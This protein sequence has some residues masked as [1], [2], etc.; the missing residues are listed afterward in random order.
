[1]TGKGIMYATGGSRG[2]G[3]EGFT[4]H[5]ACT[6]CAGAEPATCELALLPQTPDLEALHC[7]DKCSLQEL[8]RAAREQ[9]CRSALSEVL[10]RHF[11]RSKSG[12][13]RT[14]SV[15]QIHEPQLAVICRY[16]VTTRKRVYIHTYPRH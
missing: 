15:I 8:F 4:W 7:D 13:P 16:P 12:V 2:G 10:P 3:K 9:Q 5:L 6:A 1:M 11:V 14:K